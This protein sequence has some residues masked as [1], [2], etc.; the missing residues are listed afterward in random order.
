VDDW[1]DDDLMALCDYRAASRRARRRGEPFLQQFSP[2]GPVVTECPRTMDTRGSLFDYFWRSRDRIFGRHLDEVARRQPAGTRPTVFVHSHTH[3]ADRGQE[4]ALSVAAGFL[5][6]P[7]QGF[8]PVRGA[9]APIVING[10]AWQRTIM[11]VQFERLEAERS[12]SDAALLRALQPEDLPACY[13]FVHVAPYTDEPVPNVRYW[14][15]SAN[16]GWEMAG[17]CGR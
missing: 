11:P 17:A 1:S 13:G 3:V 15:R 8:S 14:R 2:R 5:N 4:S 6:I 10:G 9:L 7:P 16:E 12:L